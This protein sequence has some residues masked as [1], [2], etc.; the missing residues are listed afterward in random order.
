MKAGILLVLGVI[1]FFFVFFLFGLDFT[2]LFSVKDPLLLILGAISFTLATI[3]VAFRTRFFLKSSGEKYHGLY[4][5][6]EIELISKIFYYIAPG[7]F[8]I[9]AKALLLSS[10]FELSK[11]KALSICM[12]EYVVDVTVMI[13]LAILGGFLFLQGV[14]FKISIQNILISVII[15]FIL[16]IAYFFVPQK[17]F[18]KIE[19]KISKIRSG[20]IRKLFSLFFKIAFNI[21]EVWPGVILKR[22]TISALFFVLLAWVFTGLSM[23]LVF[24]AYGVYVP[25]FWVLTISAFSVF[26]AGISQI[27]G[28]VGARELSMVFLFVSLGV[29]QDLVVIAAVVTRIYT[30]IP[31]IIGY[32]FLIKSRKSLHFDI[33]SILK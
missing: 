4:K 10:E 7:R 27:P 8:N 15:I 30:I 13:A 33:K 31:I 14:F 16:A 19:K 12:L 22:R 18:K 20:K 1:A 24:L 25:I 26:V 9:P 2:M 17:I 23:E 28:G 29:P 6:L 3:V 32:A 11:K 21:R 5:L